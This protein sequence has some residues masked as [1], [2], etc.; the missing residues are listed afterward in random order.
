MLPEWMDGPFPEID[1]D[2]L[3]SDCDKWHR[4]TAKMAKTIEGA[5]LDVVHK[6]RTRLEDFQVRFE[7]KTKRN[8]MHRYSFV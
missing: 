2:A 5:A 7:K 3:A 6:M 1:A 4:A 8:E